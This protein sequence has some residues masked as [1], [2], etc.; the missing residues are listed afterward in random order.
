MNQPVC[1]KCSAPLNDDLPAGMCPACLL[2][3]SQRPVDDASVAETENPGPRL[4]P[5]QPSELQTLF[6][7]FEIIR[8]VGFGGMGAVYQ[9]KQKNLDRLVALKVFL[10]RDADGQFSDRF[11]REARALARMNHPNIVTVHD[12]GQRDTL[13]YLVMEFIDGANLRQLAVTQS[14]GP[15]KALQLVPQLCDALQYAHDNGVVHRDI[16]PENVLIDRSGNIKIADFGLAKLTDKSDVSLTHSQQVMGTMNYMAP[17]QHERPTDVDHRADIYSL[18]VVIYELLT[19]ELPLGRFDPPSKKADIDDRLDEVVL[20]ALAKEPDRRYQQVSE[21]KT[22]VE[23]AAIPRPANSPNVMSHARPKVRSARNPALD[24]TVFVV[25]MF[26]GCSCALVFATKHT[27][28]LPFSHE[29]IDVIGIMLAMMCGF[30][31]ATKGSIQAFSEP[32][33]TPIERIAALL[34]ILAMAIGFAGAAVF[35][36]GSKYHDSRNLF[37][38][39]GLGLCI[40]SGFIYMVAGVIRSNLQ[41]HQ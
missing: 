40:G 14:M 39:I 5:P 18:G 28:V 13:N 10:L 24:I 20:R 31:F 32:G 21:L 6:P 4:D 25:A 8:M 35:I 19:G 38:A 22:G 1:N 36:L 41:S 3:A 16:K 30:V 7:E 9:A 27:N 33:R 26:F 2:L 37:N 17:E 23:H 12:F 11:A 15:S 29:T 34:S